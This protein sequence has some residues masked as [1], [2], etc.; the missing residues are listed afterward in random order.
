MADPIATQA[1]G[2]LATVLRSIADGVIA[3]DADARVAFMNRA[4]EQLTGWTQ[5][6]ARG[7]PVDD[8][9]QL[10]DEKTGQ[11]EAWPVREAL[12]QG[13]P[14]SIPE[15]TVLVS[16][17]GQRCSL[18]DVAS[19]VYDEQGELTGAVIVFRDVTERRQIEDQLR[20]I[21]REAYRRLNELVEQCAVDRKS[22]AQGER[23]V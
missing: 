23:V 14:V 17:T 9:L 7:K 12:A 11:R 1:N 5:A 13:Q 20:D 6:E 16:R 4:A 8:V 19:P 10:V 21:E 22:V 3:T 2:W 18:N 15:S